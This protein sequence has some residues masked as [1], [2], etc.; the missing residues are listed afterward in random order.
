MPETNMRRGF[1]LIEM[2]VVITIIVLLAGLILPSVFRAKKRALIV[3]AQNFITQLD[4]SLQVYH[5]FEMNGDYPPTSLRDISFGTN[6][7]NDGIEALM[8]CLASKE[9][10]EPYFIPPEDR[11]GNNDKDKIPDSFKND[12]GVTT[13]DA[14]E[15]TDPWGNPYVY[16]H[17]KDYDAS[18]ADKKKLKYKTGKGKYVTVTPGR[19]KVTKDFHNQHK[20][21]IWSFGPDGKNDNGDGDDICNWS[22]RK[23]KKK[24]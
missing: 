17:W 20:Y 8:A 1:T 16:V 10:G 23:G 11:I 12:R 7:V 19:S 9:S 3:K 18:K 5:D 21:M 15:F 14:Y 4:A 6:G 2:L 13:K 24:K 22:K